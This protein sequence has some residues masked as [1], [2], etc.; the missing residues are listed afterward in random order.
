MKALS[1]I[2]KDSLKNGKSNNRGIK[3]SIAIAVLIISLIFIERYN[4]EINNRNILES[5][6]ETFVAIMNP[7]NEEQYKA[8]E[9]EA[10]IKK[11]LLSSEKI[12]NQKNNIRY[13]S[14]EKGLLQFDKKKLLQGRK[15][16]NINEIAVPE[17]FIRDNSEYTVGSK[18]KLGEDEKIIT[19]IY[20]GNLYSFEKQYNFYGVLNKENIKDTNTR[21]FAYIWLKH[22]RVT[23]KLLPA[24]EK[25]I[26]SQSNNKINIE[27]SK[28]Y[29]GLHH[30][31][32]GPIPKD[33]LTN[34]FIE[35][36]ILL[37]LILL[38]INII[39]N[40]FMVW[41]TRDLRDIGLLKSVGMT[42]KQTRNYLLLKTFKLSTIPILLGT[43]L[44]YVV[45]ELI[46]LGNKLYRVK[47]G[48]EEDFSIYKVQFD[49]K[50]VVCIIIISY[51]I[52]F[53]AA[54]K[55]AR[56][57][58]KISIIDAIKNNFKVK[59][60]K[61]KNREWKGNILKALAKDNYVSY[62]RNYLAMTLSL[63]A[64]C[65]VFS[66]L[67]I[68]FSC[69]SLVEKY[70]TFD[71]P[72]NINISASVQKEVNPKLISKLEEDTRIKDIIVYSDTEAYI[73]GDK[74][75]ILK[76]NGRVPKLDNLVNIYGIEDSYFNEFLSSKGIDYKKY[77]GSEYNAI[78]L[79]KIPSNP[80]K[81]Y[82]RWKNNSYINPNLK[83]LY[84]KEHKSLKDESY[85]AYFN[86]LDRVNELPK[87][88]HRVEEESM[89]IMLPLSQYNKYYD[90]RFYYRSG[91]VA[92][93]VRIK[94]E[95]IKGDENLIKE[96]INEIVKSYMA[97]SDYR[98][99]SIKDNM[100][101]NKAINSGGVTIA[102]ALMCFML[103]VGF[104]NAYCSMNMTLKARSKDISVI[105]SVGLEPKGLLK[106][107][108]LES[109]IIFRKFLIIIVVAVILY[110]G[111]FSFLLGGKFS[112]IELVYNMNW[113]SFIVYLA[114]LFLG[115]HLSTQILFKNML[116]KSIV[117][118][119]RNE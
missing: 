10:S 99:T 44:A 119:I 31:Y 15:A 48:I 9:K 52:I 105:R 92:K 33:I 62:K 38:F 102:I 7:L 39:G 106:S 77:Y 20:K 87:N 113:I 66:I 94:I 63:I 95:T 23:Y 54:L 70:D 76:D 64:S 100:N 19:G 47:L 114:V 32:N 21:L 78:A 29:L 34:M 55:P 101:L 11:I 43:I 51:I 107:F 115:I 3:V 22:P 1:F 83:Q 65:L 46:Y 2:V 53:I 96:D 6:T 89:I 72:F 85:N 86:I 30:I 73:E 12:Y 61:Y 74:K 82:K 60:V 13:I 116:S 69:E 67:L 27:Y 108:K 36:A 97:E 37:L 98:I 91:N 118:S 50:I 14:Y 75:K 35:G 25:K 112:A 79:D 71:N 68:N 45:A 81:P 111:A 117:E 41:S 88:F 28:G 109:W 56:I 59:H 8:L 40:S 17:E 49:W 103:L 80:E 84:L 5:Y 26:S 110:A 93:I 104:T 4:V 90:N 58:N 57:S 42:P 16:E 18:I 24:L